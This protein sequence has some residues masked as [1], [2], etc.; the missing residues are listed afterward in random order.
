MDDVVEAVPAPYPRYFDNADLVEFKSTGARGLVMVTPDGDG[1]DEPLLRVMLADGTAVTPADLHDLTVVDRGCS[2][3]RTQIVTLAADSGGGGQVGVVMGV[4]TELDLIRMP[5]DDGDETEAVVARGVSPG[6]LRRVT[7]LCLGDLVVS[8]PWL[9]RVVAVYVDVDVAFDGGAAVCR[10]ARANADGGNKL[11]GAGKRERYSRVFQ[12]SVYYPGQRVGVPRGSSVFEK[13]ATW[14]VGGWSPGRHTRGTVV[15]VEMADALVYWLASAELGIIADGDDDARAAAPP[16]CVTNANELTVF[17]SDAGGSWAVGDRCFFLQN[18][19]SSSDDDGYVVV[20][21]GE[22]PMCVADARTSVDVLWQDGTRQRGVPSASLLPFAGLDYE[23]DFFPGEVVVDVI[24]DDGVYD[25][26]DATG[27][28]DDDDHY[29][30]A[31]EELDLERVGIVRSF[32]CKDRTAHVS[33]FK[34]AASGNE[35]PSAEEVECHD[36]IVS[37]YH[38]EKYD[39]YNNVFY[40]NIVVRPPSPESS[41]GDGKST[42]VT[43]EYNKKA[44][45]DLSWVGQVVDLCDGYVQVKWG[46]GS[47]SEVLRHEIDFLK[48]PNIDALEQEILNGNRAQEDPPQEPEANDNVNVAAV[49]DNGEG[50][51]DSADG[52]DEED[53]GVEGC[54][55]EDLSAEKV[56]AGADS[57]DGGSLHFMQFDVIQSPSDHHYLDNKEQGAGTKWMKRVQKEWKILE[58]NLPGQITDFA[59]TIYVRA[60]EDRMDLLRVAMVGAVG[61]PYQD[62]LFF[63]DLQLPPKYPAVP[64]LVHYHSF[65]LNLNPN[66]EVSGTVCISLLDTYDGEGVELWSPA[67][68]TVLQVVVSIQ[69]LVLTAEPYYNEPGHEGSIMGARNALPY[70]ENAYLLSLQIMLHLL[71][72]PPAGFEE[73]VRAHF[74][75]RG[76]FVLQK[77]AAYLRQDGC[78]FDAEERPCSEGFKLALA[79]VVPQLVEA[80]TNIGAEGCEEFDQVLKAIKSKLDHRWHA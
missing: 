27:D 68:S 74:R 50:D 26:D 60:F 31:S 48:V 76:K 57:N 55:D 24:Y 77:C 73:L 4:S 54:A 41:G 43:T 17:H 39:Y 20:E 22:P 23:Q 11:L 75:R 37:V 56:K 63:F 3:S 78:T 13:E 69:A 36:E 79:G 58:N 47:T 12:N 71:R 45:A 70:A 65:G 64:P 53:Y 66:L 52:S 16:A 72:R 35:E 19:H 10:V 8:G 62:G 5:Q 34:P 32:N 7:R 44:A 59:D 30:T 15:N 42:Q 29:A 49:S 14:L 25:D 33:W 9:G 18:T 40:G 6:E 28:A 38:L 21:M 2:M 1:D 67:M 61:T 46:D 80:F 51:G